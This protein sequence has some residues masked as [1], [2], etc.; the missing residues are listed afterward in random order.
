MTT[1]GNGY[2]TLPTN[3][4]HRLDNVNCAYCGR[5]FDDALP[6]SLEHVIGR[7][8]VPRGALNAN[9]NLHV[10][11]CGGCNNAQSGALPDPH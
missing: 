5:L 1:S 4:V 11:V 6:P 10:N 2:S 8:F 3:R 9:F 7:K